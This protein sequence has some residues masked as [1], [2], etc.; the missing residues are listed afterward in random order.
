[1]KKF[2]SIVLTLLMPFCA[3][4]APLTPEAALQRA[5]GDAP[6]RVAGNSGSYRL[7]TTRQ[8]NGSDAI[9]VFTRPASDGFIVT[10]ADDRAP[11]LLGYGETNLTDETGNFA[12]GMTYW[13][14]QLARQVEYDASHE[15]SRRIS[16]ARPEREAI[17]PLCKTLWNQST[18]YNDLCPE[19]NGERSVTG[20]VATAMS[21]AM[22]YHNWPAT[23][24]GSIAYDWN[25]TT[26]SLDFSGQTF[27]WSRMLETYTGHADEEQRNAVAEL[28]RAAGYSVGMSYSPYA[29]GASS[30]AIAPALGN[31]FR[32][33]KSSLRYLERDHYSLYD[34][35][36]IIYNSLLKDGP[37][38]YDGQS[39]DGGHSYIC[40]GYASDGYFHF[41]WGWGGISDGY[42]LLDAL[43]PIEQGIGGAAAGFNFMQDVIVGIR[44]DKTGNSTWTS[45]LAYYQP[46]NIILTTYEEQD[47]LM[48][49]NLL[50]NC[51]PGTINS[52]Q[53]GMCFQPIDAAGNMTGEP[54]YN[55]EE[56]DE[57]L[58][59]G[60]GISGFGCYLNEIPDGRYIVSMVYNLGDGA[61]YIPVTGATYG[62]SSYIF[63]KDET[64]N[65]LAPVLPAVP[66]FDNA[67]FPDRVILN[68]NIVAS[69]TLTNNSD[70][71]CHNFATV[72]ILSTDGKSIMARGKMMVFDLE[73]GESKELRYDT[74]FDT[75]SH[76]KSGKYL[77]AMAVDGGQDDYVLISEPQPIIYSIRPSAVSDIADDQTSRTRIYFTIGGV[78]VAEAGAGE[79]QPTLPAGMYIVK[80]GSST[81]KIIVK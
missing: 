73:P 13:L 6:R 21:Q 33:D 25:E 75:Q 81:D 58:E 16:K 17:E 26:L 41:N 29:S 52:A 2:P 67:I 60:Y 8:S 66:D 65:E 71:P 68:Q 78:R 19:V 56:L 37:V 61:E 20:C 10:P 77:I 48:Q 55:T 62:V 30:L 51:G 14:D 46:L 64:G 47:V 42:F 9:Y 23:G 59:V 50:Y 80:S 54:I 34:W 32:Y 57:T 70:R 72:L 28:M 27:K 31:Y 44:P 45:T 63:Q 15:G 40:D 18:P 38:I 1:M 69:G 53:I 7:A 76:M 79:A 39:Y 4:A 24:E 74:P 36:E 12:P 43:D 3:Q 5:L 49:T 11:A 22:K 35:E